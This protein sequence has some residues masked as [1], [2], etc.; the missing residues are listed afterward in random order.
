MRDVLEYRKEQRKRGEVRGEEGRG[1]EGRGEEAMYTIPTQ[2]VLVHC[3]NIYMCIYM[4]YTNAMF[5]ILNVFC[6]KIMATGL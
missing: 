5:V 1:E 3:M 2:I 6:Q 4:K